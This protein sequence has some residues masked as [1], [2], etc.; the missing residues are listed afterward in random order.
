MKKISTYALV[1]FGVCVPV[2]CSLLASQQE[3]TINDE[4]VKLVSFE[5]L[6]YPPVARVTRIQGVVVVKAQLDDQ[7]NVATAFAVS[8][9][10]ALIPD[11]LS[12][13]KKWKFKPNSSKSVVIVYEFRLGDGA[14]HNDSHSLF[15][16]RHPNFASI[17]SCDPVIR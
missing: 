17:T 15:L 4:D 8:G 6:A 2:A 11:C 1:V 5:D 3:I 9:S 14:C 13:A 12:N 16:L 7:G 10:K